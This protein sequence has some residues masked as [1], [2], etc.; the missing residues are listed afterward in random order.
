MSS[1]AAGARDRSRLDLRLLAPALVA[2]AVAAAGL[3]WGAPLRWACV[4]GCA[5]VAAGGLWWFRRP[6]RDRARVVA[7]VLT[8]SGILTALLLGVSTLAE[9]SRQQGLVARAI[10]EEA[11]VSAEVTLTADARRVVSE[12]RF[13]RSELVLLRARAH[14][15]EYRGQ[16][17]AANAP[18]LVIA[19]PGSGWDELT[20]RTRLEVTGLVEPSDPGDDVVA[21]LSPAKGP[22]EVRPPG[23]GWRVAEGLREGLRESMDP[24][25]ADARGLVPGLVLGDT[26]L[27]PEE[28]TEA[29][30]E[31]GMTHLSA[32]SGSN[33][34][35]VVGAVLWVCTGVGVPR[36]L[37]PWAAA[38][39]LGGF[40]VLARPEPSVLR[41]GV[42]GGVALVGMT[43]SRRA[44]SLPALATSMVLLLVWDPWLARSY[45]FALS[46]LA[47]LGLVLFVRPWAEALRRR[48]PAVPEPV[49]QALVIPVAAALTTAPVVAM[50][51]GQVSVVGLLTNLAAAPLV[52][53]A[54]V[55]G[56]VVVLVHPVA[57]PVADAIAWVAA[58][59]AQ[60]IG[61]IA[62]AGA[63]VPHGAVP[64]PADG[65]GGLV[66]AVVL[67]LVVVSGPPLVR[68]L[69]RPGRWRDVVT[70]SAGCTALVLVVLW[71][72]PRLPAAVPGLG[73][74]G[75]ATDWRVVM[76]D[77]GQ[78]DA[79][80]VRTAPDRAVLV[81]T[82][83]PGARTPSCL[84]AAGV[85]A[86]DVVVVTHAHADHS[87]NLGAVLDAVPVGA[88]WASPSELARP[89]QPGHPAEWREVARA[90][91]TR[92]EPFAAGDRV[93][94]GAARLTAVWPRAGVDVAPDDRRNDG[95]LVLH[96]E[97]GA[98]GQAPRAAGQAARPAAG[99]AGGARVPA[100][101][102]AAPVRVLLTG[103]LEETGG[104][105]VQ[106]LTAEVPVD[107]LK[108]PHHGSAHQGEALLA[109]GAPLAL[110]SAGRDND[111]GHPAPAT[112]ER[113]DAAGSTVVGTVEHGDVAVGASDT[114]LWWARL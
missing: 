71:A 97:V 53:P 23:G 5:L 15:I 32:V 87:G 68:L 107:V 33:V 105:A 2:W 72:G 34:A 26:S 50:L 54:T 77:V 109:R 106:A 46:V 44:A 75:A 55:G 91:G 111:H 30:T 25:W 64:W 86:L 18:V 61:W 104:A 20:W 24:V 38:L 29:M 114:G 89:M 103:D 3:A 36:R 6:G 40:V 17:S 8:L 14:H 48:W 35:I 82:G 95:S 12:G 66:L 84:R 43:A 85:R 102:G 63:A 92:I 57:E 31:T 108:V 4:G 113:L 80:L 79:F 7:A 16:E 76:C 21:V 28:L 88:V 83:P 49:A 19:R 10:A 41:A 27:T 60:V 94:L 45:G 37:R 65:R 59:P 67:A 112:L 69:A 74:A 51:Q 62:R 81:D 39:A 56:V 70:A 47:T 52:A 1:R 13:G 100:D 58:A 99:A 101:G 9:T 98:A 22:Q 11:V 78:G 96:A 93:D 42:M 90:R 110:V 73:S